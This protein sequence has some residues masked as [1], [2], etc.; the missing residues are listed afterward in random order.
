MTETLPLSQTTTAVPAVSLF[1]QPPVSVGVS[2]GWYATPPIVTGTP[3]DTVPPFSANVP[4]QFDSVPLNEYV[5]V[6]DATDSGLA[7]DASPSSV[8][9][10]TPCP[11]YA[12]V[13]ATAPA[14]APA[15]SRNLFT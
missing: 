8:Q 12:G 2:T 1:A 11:A 6:T 5:V 15:S 3:A 14:T 13:H 7:N 10:P 4:W 9:P